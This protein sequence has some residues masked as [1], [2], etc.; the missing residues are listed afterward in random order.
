MAGDPLFCPWLICRMQEP[1]FARLAG[2]AFS[3][4][5][6][7]DLAAHGLDRRPPDR[8]P[9]GPNDDPADDR[10]AMDPDDGLPWPEPH[11]LADWWGAHRAQFPPGVRSFMG[12]PPGALHCAAVLREGGQ[13]QRAA[14]AAYLC[15]L[16]PGTPLFPTRAPAWRQQRWLTAGVPE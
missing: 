3:W 9:A 13:R 15:L 5:T 2:E 10:V 12:A 14:A 11:K 7:I 1:A 16:H 6:G 4:I 8:V